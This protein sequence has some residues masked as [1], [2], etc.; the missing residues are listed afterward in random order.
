M[1]REGLK[2]EAEGL[3]LGVASAAT[4]G[5]EAVIVSGD[6]GAGGLRGVTA[7]V[8]HVWFLAVGLRYFEALWSNMNFAAEEDAWQSTRVH[9]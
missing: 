7:K 5:F 8:G 1:Q 3:H 2:R 9:R 4:T 6:L